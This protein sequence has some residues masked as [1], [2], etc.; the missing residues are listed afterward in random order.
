MIEFEFAN[1][2]K[3][4]LYKIQGSESLVITHIQVIMRFSELFSILKREN[5]NTGRSDDWFIFRSDLTEVGRS[6]PFPPISSR[7][8]PGS[9]HWSAKYYG[10]VRQLP[11]EYGK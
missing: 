11:D 1:S 8:H 3:A 9:R 10:A 6:I 4:E 2:V 5:R 7:A